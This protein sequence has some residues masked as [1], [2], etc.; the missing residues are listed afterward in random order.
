MNQLQWDLQDKDPNSIKC[1]RALLIGIISEEDTRYTA[2]AH[3]DELKDL[4]ITMGIEP[5]ESILVNA[6]TPHPRFLVGSGKAEEIMETAEEIETDIC[7]F[8]ASLSPRQQR[9]LESLNPGIAVIDREEV[10]LDIFADRAQT[11]EAVLQIELARLEYSLPRLTRAW[12]HLS[13]QR[14]GAKGNRGKGETQLES[15]R[16]YVQN[17]ITKLKK[18]IKQV[19]KT[20][21]LMRQKRQKAPYPTLALAGYTN[22]GKSSLLK[23]ISGA[24]VLVEN[25]LF[26]TL[27]PMSRKIKLPGGRPVILTDTVGFIRKL[28]HHLIDAFKSTLEEVALADVIVHVIDASNEEFQDHI[29][30]SHEIFRELGAGNIY[31]IL[32]FNKSDSLEKQQI[33]ALKNL[34]PKALVVSCHKNTGMEELMREINKALDTMNRIVNIVLPADRWDLYSL[35]TRTGFIEEESFLDNELCLKAAISSLTANK[36]E[37]FI[38]DS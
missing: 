36:L 17:R 6:Q 31:E 14:G 11:K 9:N 24:D 21:D 3:L 20:R 8:D 12:T 18:E 30:V 28:P 10:I 1:E 16:R 37:E 5:V 13:R 38:I 25:K 15:D 33:N 2:K 32:V 34:F 27:D 22:A 26:A 23:R 7:I 29:K 35:I 4:V 19:G